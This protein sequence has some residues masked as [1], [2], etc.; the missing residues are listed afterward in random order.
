M[1]RISKK[2]FTLM[3][4]LIYIG[5]LGLIVGTVSSFLIWGINSHTKSKVMRETLDN[6]RRAMEIMGYEI[7]EAKSIYTPTTTANQLSLETTH[8]LPEG[9]K[10]SFI[11]FYLCNSH[12][13]LE[14]ESQ[15]PIALTSDNLEVSNLVFTQVITGN[16][17]SIQISL[18]VNYKNPTNRPEYQAEVESISAA[19]LRNY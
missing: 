8:H 18:K 14:K 5:V 11:D 12:L 7:R 10:T 13:C 4:I 2:A 17:P 1:K 3:E 16:I 19:S 6:A 15:D 9:E